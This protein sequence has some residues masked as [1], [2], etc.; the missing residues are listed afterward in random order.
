MKKKLVAILLVIVLVFNF[1][2]ACP[3]YAGE[4]DDEGSIL[5]SSNGEGQVTA[6]QAEGLINN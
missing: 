6:E 2:C 3:G 5:P 1:I 4:P